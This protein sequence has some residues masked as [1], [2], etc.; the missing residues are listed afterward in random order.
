MTFGAIGG[1]NIE[2]E[3]EIATV[4]DAIPGWYAPRVT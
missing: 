2:F 4:G 1:Q 3:E